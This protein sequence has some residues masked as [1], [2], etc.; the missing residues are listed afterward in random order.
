MRMADEDL[1]L[2]E[3]E[4][5]DSGDPETAPTPMVAI[6]IRLQKIPLNALS[7]SDLRL[8][9]GQQIGLKYLVPK[10]LDRLTSLPLLQTDYYPGDLLNALLRIDWDYWIQNPRELDCV[11]SIAGSVAP[12]Y[13]ELVRDC[14]KFLAT[15]HTDKQTSQITELRVD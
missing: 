4:G 13:G 6:C 3:L 7:D 14:E 5:Y 11:R 15:H 9:I 8:L 2:E 10:A 1:T 12:Q